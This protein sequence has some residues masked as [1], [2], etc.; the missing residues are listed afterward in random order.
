MWTN[1]AIYRYHLWSCEKTAVEKIKNLDTWMII[2]IYTDK[3]ARSA[4]KKR[5]R[6]LLRDTGPEAEAFFI[7]G[8]GA[9]GQILSVKIPLPEIQWDSRWCQRTMKSRSVLAL[10]LNTQEVLPKS[11]K[12]GTWLRNTKPKLS[13]QNQSKNP[14]SM[15][16]KRR[17]DKS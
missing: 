8:H 6:A 9:R 12:E 2:A 11:N 1:T 16:R 4:Q 5:G 3:D 14:F 7:Q 17:R 10:R 15:S 13:G